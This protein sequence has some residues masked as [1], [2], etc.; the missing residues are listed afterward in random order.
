MWEPDKII[1]NY[2][3]EDNVPR[4]EIL[5]SQFKKLRN[6]LTQ[7][8]EIAKLNITNLILLQNFATNSN[9]V[10][11]I[12]KGIRSLIKLSHSSRKEISLLN[13]NRKTI[14]DPL[15]ISTYF[16]QNFVSM[17]PNIDNKICKGKFHYSHYLSNVR[18]NKS[19]F[20]T[21][22]TPKEVYNI[23]LSLDLNKS[24]GPNS[25]RIFILKICNDFSHIIFPKL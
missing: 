4:R 6:E 10:A 16:N 21:P 2:C 5:Y 9:K 13:D 20:L 8:S 15:K 3:K 22:V 23:I 18:I 19:F 11:N 17:G 12:W 1:H 24:V 14:T 7:K 25:L